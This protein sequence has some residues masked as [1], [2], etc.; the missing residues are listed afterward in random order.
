MERIWVRHSFFLKD[1]SNPSTMVR[2]SMAEF[3]FGEFRSKGGYHYLIELYNEQMSAIHLAD[4]KS[5]IAILQGIH[6]AHK[7]FL[8]ITI[9]VLF[10]SG[11][12]ASQKN[13]CRSAQLGAWPCRPLH[14]D[15]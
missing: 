6:H 15:Y 3:F 7:L 13:S 9:R 4:H 5:C 2:G 1:M 10:L 12:E 14:S 11:Y 8:H